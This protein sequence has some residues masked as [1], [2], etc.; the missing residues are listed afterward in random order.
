MPLRKPYHQHKQGPA[1]PR[2]PEL[3]RPQ[4]LGLSQ[5]PTQCPSLQPALNHPTV[6][7]PKNGKWPRLQLS[8][9]LSVTSISFVFSRCFAD[10]AIRNLCRQDWLKTHEGGT[11]DDFK[12]YWLGLSVE[13]IVVRVPAFLFSCSVPLIFVCL[14]RL[15]MEI[16]GCFAGTRCS[17]PIIFCTD[18]SI[19]SLE[20]D[21]RR[22]NEQERYVSILHRDSLLIHFFSLMFFCR[23]QDFGFSFSASR[24]RTSFH[25]RSLFDGMLILATFFGP[26][27]SHGM[28]DRLVLF[29]TELAHGL[30]LSL[31]DSCSLHGLTTLFRSWTCLTHG[32][33]LA[34]MVFFFI[35]TTDLCFFLLLCVWCWG[36]W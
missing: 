15:G 26:P 21:S 3:R 6:P 22:E 24:S 9:M 14:R 12:A 1:L 16:C 32:P 10:C 34:L 19:P 29:R 35:A 8:P 30:V 7:L 17:R 33:M 31:S 27:H 23:D 5:L 18:Y 28:A 11:E 13:Q 4:Q 25:G 36:N 2:K 20:K